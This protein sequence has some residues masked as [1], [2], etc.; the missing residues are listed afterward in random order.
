MF[1]SSSEILSTHFSE[2]NIAIGRVD[3]IA[4]RIIFMITMIGTDNNIPTTPQREPQNTSDRIITNGERL[5]LFH[6]N[7]GSTKFHMRIC[8]QIISTKNITDCHK[9]A[10]STNENRTG[11][12]T[13]MIDP[14]LGIKFKKNIINAKN[15]A[16]GKPKID[17]IV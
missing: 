7:F 8:T 2:N 17:I 4:A 14:M 6:T 5:S 9:S 10:N 3:G 11:N 15:I 12:N 16:K 1:T 13:A